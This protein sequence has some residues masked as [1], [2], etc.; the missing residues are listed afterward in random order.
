MAKSRM[1]R[2]I[3][4]VGMFYHVHKKIGESPAREDV[5]V[6]VPK[7]GEWACTIEGSPDEPA[8]CFVVKDYHELM[9]LIEALELARDRIFTQG[10]KRRMAEATDYST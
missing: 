9:R 7:S 1:L 8:R 2:T 5:T 3:N 6:F 10:T 4:G